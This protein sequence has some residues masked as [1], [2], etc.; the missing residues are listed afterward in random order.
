MARPRLRLDLNWGGLLTAEGTPLVQVVP[1]E[2][3]SA[4][5]EGRVLEVDGDRDLVHRLAEMGL[6]EGVQVRMVRSG[7]PCIL[8][9]ENHR[10]TFRTDEST[11]VLVEVGASK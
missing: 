2:L 10:L 9:I 6:R 7:S 11:T 4:G 5:E 1:L 8:A 3:L